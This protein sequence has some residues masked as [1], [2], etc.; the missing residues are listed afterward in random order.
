MPNLDEAGQKLV[1][2]LSKL[3]DEVHIRFQHLE[4]NFNHITHDEIKQL[5]KLINDE[6]TALKAHI[7]HLQ[8]L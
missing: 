6:K 3:N 5:S 2:E 4:N 1:R 7:E 8:K